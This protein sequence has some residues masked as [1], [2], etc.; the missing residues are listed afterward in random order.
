MAGFNREWTPMDAN[1]LRAFRRHGNTWSC[2]HRRQGVLTAD[3][4]RWTLMSYDSGDAIL[5]PEWRANC[6]SGSRCQATLLLSRVY[7]RPSAVKVG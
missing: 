4:R 2:G 6:N 7:L 1:E 3:G 5:Q